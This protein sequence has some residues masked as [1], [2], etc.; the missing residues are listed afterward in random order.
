MHGAAI[1]HALKTKKKRGAH[2]VNAYTV[3]AE[4]TR[5]R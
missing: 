1:A 2:E 4:A 5:W 3:G